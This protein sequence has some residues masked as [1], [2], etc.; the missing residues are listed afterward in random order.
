MKTLV[1]PGKIFVW[2]DIYRWLK[3][4]AKE[5]GETVQDCLATMLQ[6]YLD[7]AYAEYQEEHYQE[8]LSHCPKPKRRE[9]K[10][11]PKS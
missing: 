1:Q 4:Q 6:D 5:D 3:K 2:P 8:F 9:K 11:G 10:H 7:K